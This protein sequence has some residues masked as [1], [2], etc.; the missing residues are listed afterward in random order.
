MYCDGC[1][2]QLPEGA[3]FCPVCGKAAGGSARPAWPGRVARHLRVVGILWLIYGALHL[4]AGAVFWAV[5]SAV[6]SGAPF[7]T[8]H[9]WQRWHPMMFPWPFHMLAGG[10]LTGLATLFVLIA[11]AGLLAG[12]GLLER[13]GWAR[14][15][16]LVLA[17]LALFN[18][19]WG[20]ALGIYTLWVLLPETSAHEYRH[21]AGRA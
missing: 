18:L 3:N 11:I 15:L 16:V 20:T 13:K 19:P 1:G 14:T 8:W 10:M 6:T 2:K 21:V 9:M 7:G 4:L 12:W 5:G 17:V